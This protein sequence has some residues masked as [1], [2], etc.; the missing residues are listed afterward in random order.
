MTDSPELDEDDLKVLRE[1]IE[2][3]KAAKL[4][5]KWFTTFLGVAI[6]IIGIYAFWK[7]LGGNP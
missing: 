4:I 3:E 7:S 6:P 1:I 2:R 5:W